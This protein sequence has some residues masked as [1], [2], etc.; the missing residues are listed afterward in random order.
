[1]EPLRNALGIIQGLYNFLR[2]SP[3]RHAIFN[4]MNVEEDHLRLTLK[5]LSITRWSCRW[6]AVKAVIEQQERI[7][8]TLLKLSVDKNAKTYAD[9]R[10]LLTSLC[11]FEFVFGLHVLKVMQHQ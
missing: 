3:K 4:Y 11:D 7:V 5:S 9:A 6:E 2:A 10:C 8:K 1:V